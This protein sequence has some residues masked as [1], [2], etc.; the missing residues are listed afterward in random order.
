MTFVP[1]LWLI[2]AYYAALLPFF[3]LA[4][5]FVSLC[6]VTDERRIG[7][8][9][10]ADLLG[11]AAG[12][13]SVL[14]LMWLL[15][16]LRLVPAMLVP[17]ALA[18]LGRG[19]WPPLAAAAVLVGGEALLLL[20]PA[21][22][23]DFKAIYAPSH[24]AGARVLATRLSPR[25][26][27]ALLDDF[28]ERVDTD[29]SNDSGGLGLPGPPRTLGLYRDGARL[30]ALPLPPGRRRPRRRGARPR[31][32]RRSRRRSLRRRRSRPGH[33]RRRRHPGRLRRRREH[34]RRRRHGRHPGRL[35]RRGHPR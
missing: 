34:P 32:R 4:G 23:N 6:F 15:P 25:G 2:G 5:V 10:G 8:V 14:A 12:A 20:A 11:A 21:P 16:P 3:F 18:T 13:A 30:A 7:R 33:L 31:A 19:R 22:V 24:V 17:L 9:Y 1:Q 27:Y 29:L 26:E 28:T 35:R